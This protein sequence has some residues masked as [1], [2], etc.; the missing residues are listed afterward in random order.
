MLNVSAVVST[1]R[2]TSRLP[3]IFRLMPRR[4]T[5]SSSGR[6][7]SLCIAGVLTDGGPRGRDDDRACR[8]LC[9]G[10]SLRGSSGALS[11]R[12]TAST[13]DDMFANASRLTESCSSSSHSSTKTQRNRRFDPAVG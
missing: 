4:P 10:A 2:G 9:E 7:T 8:L 11:D 6:P 1:I 12:M 13:S 5:I 3:G